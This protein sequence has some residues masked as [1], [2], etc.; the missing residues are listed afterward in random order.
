LSLAQATGSVTSQ[1]GAVATFRARAD[2]VL[3]P[4]TVT[5]K[6]NRFVLGLQEADFH[7]FEDGVEQTVKHFSGEDAP[8]SIGILFDESGS[9]GSGF[10]PLVMPLS[11]C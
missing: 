9:M 4:V 1:E 6:L 2:L 5:D 8:L 7:L 11:S 10:L 3:I